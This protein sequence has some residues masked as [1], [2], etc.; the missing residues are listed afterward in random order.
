VALHIDASGGLLTSSDG[1]RFFCAT[2]DLVDRLFGWLAGGRGDKIAGCD[3]GFN[4][5]RSHL[6]NGRI[7]WTPMASF[8]AR[9]AMPAFAISTPAKISPSPG[10]DGSRVV[11]HG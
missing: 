1:Q 6:L 8:A 2:D 7:I 5:A 3:G 4:V 10:L 9:A 11:G